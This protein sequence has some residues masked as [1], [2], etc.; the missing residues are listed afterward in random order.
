MDKLEQIA[1]AAVSSG[2]AIKYEGD[3]DEV[4]RFACCGEVSYH[5]HLGDCWFPRMVEELKARGHKV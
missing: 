3:E 1:I 4:G 5:N 2:P